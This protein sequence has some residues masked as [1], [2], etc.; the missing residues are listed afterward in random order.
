VEHTEEVDID[1]LTPGVGIIFIG[2]PDALETGVVDEHIEPT[3][4]RIDGG[5]CGFETSAVGHIYRDVAGVRQ[6][7]GGHSDIQ[8]HH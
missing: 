6:G 3:L 8:C 1:D 2:P 4:L 7:S 5:E